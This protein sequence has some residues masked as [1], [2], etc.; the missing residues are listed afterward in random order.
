MCTATG[1][2][3]WAVIIE[4]CKK[5]K[6]CNFQMMAR[7]SETTMQRLALL[8]YVLLL[9]QHVSCSG[10]IILS[11]MTDIFISSF[12]PWVAPFKANRALEPW[13]RYLQISLTSF[14]TETI[15][16]SSQCVYPEKQC[17]PE[18]QIQSMSRS[19]MTKDTPVQKK[20]VFVSWRFGGFHATNACGAGSML[21]L[22]QEIRAKSFQKRNL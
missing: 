13:S 19:K 3:K 17:L 20:L 10:N 6:Q 18:R 12:Q 5:F 21:P 7:W 2:L 15:L 8:C 11:Q 9:R 22:S 16:T 1:L 4:N 14:L